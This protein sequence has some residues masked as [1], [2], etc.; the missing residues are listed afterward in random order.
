MRLL[1]TF[2]HR[3]GHRIEETSTPINDDRDAEAICR[4]EVQAYKDRQGET[5]LQE[6]ARIISFMRAAVV[7]VQGTERKILTVVEYNHAR[8]TAKV[9]PQ[10]FKVDSPAHMIV[11]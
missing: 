10:I 3:Q 6:G 4:E 1:E 2:A 11:R 9:D 5:Y 8:G 7:E